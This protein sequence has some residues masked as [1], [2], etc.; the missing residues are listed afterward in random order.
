MATLFERLAQGRPPP[1]PPPTTPLAAGRLLGW[2]QNNWKEPVIRARDIQ[3]LGPRSIRNR[4]SA[5]EMAEVLVRRGGLTPM[6][7]HRHDAKWWRI[8]I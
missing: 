1:T 3:R 4:K 5:I 2:L 8:A 7:T 6:K